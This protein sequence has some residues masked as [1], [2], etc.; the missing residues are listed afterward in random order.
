M[1]IRLNPI[2]CLILF[3]GVMQGA[4]DESAR[5]NASRDDRFEMTEQPISPFQL[6]NSGVTSGSVSFMIL[7]SSEGELEDYL[8]L[9]ATNIQFGDALAKVLPK[10]TCFPQ[11]VGDRFVNTSSRIDMNFHSR[12]PWCPFRWVRTWR[13]FSREENYWGRATITTKWLL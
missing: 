7:V 8:L 5:T 3:A 11:K 1:N 2:F 13:D 9:E 4:P 12:G 6:V 10:W